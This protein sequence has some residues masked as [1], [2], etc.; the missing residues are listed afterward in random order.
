MFR[1]WKQDF[2][3]IGCDGEEHTTFHSCD[4]ALGSL[5]GISCLKRRRGD[6][7]TFLECLKITLGESKE[8]LWKLKEPWTEG[9]LKA[10][11]WKRSRAR[12]DTGGLKGPLE[13]PKNVLGWSETTIRQ[14]QNRG[15]K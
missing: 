12:K 11:A 5:K 8:I 9:S 7:K 13:A 10:R 6:L 4:Q 14:E 15:L 1:L 2:T 3:K